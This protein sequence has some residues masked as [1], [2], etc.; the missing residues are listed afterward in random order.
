VAQAGHG[1]L[2]LSFSTGALYHL[3]L[4]TAFAVAR[5]AGFDGVELV[6]GPELF[7][8]GTAHARRVSQQYGLP[9]FSVH[10]PIVP[11]PGMDDARPTVRRLL[12][13]A[14]EVDCD[15]VVLHTPKTAS[16]ATPAWRF[17]LQ[18]L[19][20]HT[21]PT[22]RVALE[23]SGFFRPGDEC[24]VLHDVRR[25]QAF[26]E[27]HDLPVTFDTAHTGT[28]P[29]PILEAFALFNG[30]VANVHLSDLARRRLFPNWRPLHTFLLHHQMPGAGV[31]PLAEFLR[32]LVRSG[33]TGPLTLELSPTALQ[34]WSLVKVRANLARA[35]DFVRDTE[36]SF[37]A[38]NAEA[39]KIDKAP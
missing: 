30:R 12:F 16:T 28:T 36:R 4:R 5:E 8:L 10:P 32:M 1:V 11:Y 18:A 9:V 35:V 13:L 39:A 20:E 37:N 31:L 2:K 21:H 6:E 3:P 29:Y 17:F 24:C 15:L 38:E 14:K 22:I 25:L 27:S 23:T 34:A 26:A 33:Y 19:Q 7:L